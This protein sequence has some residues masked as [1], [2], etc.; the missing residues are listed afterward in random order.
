MRMALLA[1]A[2]VA[3][4]AGCQSGTPDATPERVLRRYLDAVAAQDFD[5]AY[6][7]LSAVDRAVRRPGEFRPRPLGEYRITRVRTFPDIATAD[8]EVTAPPAPPASLHPDADA[9]EHT[10]GPQLRSFTLVREQQRWKVFL[11]AA[12]AA[13]LDTGAADTA[14]PPA[15]GE[16]PVLPAAPAPE[17]D[18]E[19]ADDTSGTRAQPAASPRSEPPADAAAQGIEV[20]GLKAGHY[21]TAL[22]RQVPGVE[23]RLRNRSARTATHV[24]VTVYFHDRAG[25]TIAEETYYPVRSDG[26]GFLNTAPLRPGYRWQVERGRFLLAESVPDEWHTGAV[27][28]AVTQVR[29]AAEEGR[30]SD[31]GEA[32]TPD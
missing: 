26:A 22:G 5:A 17:P 25:N 20:Y 32:G 12:G 31:R 21:R 6:A 2:F 3:A 19:E 14:A 8:V 16:A 24:T 18:D 15:D 7:Q 9:P 27:S 4:L 30:D 13:D 28:C 10:P 11:G 1:G 29:F 23:F